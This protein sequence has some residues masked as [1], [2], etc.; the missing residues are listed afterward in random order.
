MDEE[1]PVALGA[2]ERRGNEITRP[3]TAVRGQRRHALQHGPMGGRI[4]D[5]AVIRRTLADLELRLDQG[6][7]VGPRAA[8][9]GPQRRGDG[10]Q[11]EAERDERHVDDGQVDRLADEISGQ[12]PRV[13]AVVDDDPGIPGDP[14][15]KL[16]ST[17]VDGVDPGRAALEQHVRE[18]A[19]RRARVET[20]EP[21]GVD[22]EGVERGRELVPA[23]TDVG[24]LGGQLDRQVRFHEVACLAIESRA[25]AVP[26]PDL[27]AEDQR[28]GTRPAVRETAVDEELIET[29]PTAT[30]GGMA[31]PVI[32]AQP[33]S[34]RLNRPLPKTARK[35]AVSPARIV[36]IVLTGLIG[37]SGLGVGL[38]LITTFAAAAADSVETGY[39]IG[40]GIALYGLIAA[41]AAFGVWRGRL[42]AWWIALVAIAAGLLLLARFATLGGGLDAVFVGGVVLWA[43]DLAA[44]LAP[45]TRRSVRAGGPTTGR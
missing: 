21:R 11:D 44:L 34:P 18:A 9:S 39:A 24:L 42:L 38:G 26:G 41:L 16:A 14:V 19:R 6:H 7:D 36:A 45:G 23:A 29:L 8:G 13:R 40:A 32:V 33:P 20:D 3:E 1:L 31:H 12:R 35:A 22:R 5:H 4:P 37:L 15:R 30:D 43:A 17:D 25:V 27:A 2:E 10:S 28:L